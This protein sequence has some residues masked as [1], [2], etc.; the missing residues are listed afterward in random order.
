MSIPRV[1]TLLDLHLFREIVHSDSATTNYVVLCQSNDS[2]KQQKDDVISSVF[3]DSYGSSSLPNVE[4]FLLDCNEIVDDVVDGAK[5]GTTVAEYLNLNTKTY[6]TIFVSGKR[7]ESPRQIPSKHLKTGAMLSKAILKMVTPSAVKL[8]SK[9]SLRSKCLEFD[10]CVVLLKSGD[11]STGNFAWVKGL[12]TD[13]SAQFDKSKSVAVTYVDSDLHYLKNMEDVVYAV[14]DYKQNEPRFVVFR[15]TSPKGDDSR[16]KTSVAPFKKL[17]ASS[18]VLKDDVLSFVSDV[19]GGKV[20]SH[21][22]SQL[23]QLV[24]RTKKSAEQI[25][26]KRE[27]YR[28]R[29]QEKKKKQT[30]GSSGSSNESASSSSSD[31]RK[32]ERKAERDR[33]RA[34]HHRENNIREKTPE[35]I[36][37]MEAERRKRMEEEA[38]K[39]NMMDSDLGDLAD[40]DSLDDV[41]E[42]SS[43]MFEDD[44]EELV[45]VDFDSSDS[46]DDDEDI[47]DLD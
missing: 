47:L 36:K 31:D 9:S 44:E 6:P 22:L 3:V 14:P 40:E 28:A 17:D 8:E 38:A 35:E 29:A 41:D 32:A 11:V 19:N 42:N 15:R 16:L 26:V 12:M 33:R 43:Y 10:T 39:W 21:R 34:A 30:E 1:D 45:D 24:T 46:N 20:K 27:K 7:L 23:P 18:V 13:L 2:S 37:K 5:S 25:R 4:Y